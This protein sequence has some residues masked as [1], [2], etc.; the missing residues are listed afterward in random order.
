MTLGRSG[1]MGGTYP[2]T[3]A[4]EVLNFTHE[5]AEEQKKS[6]E[7]MKELLHSYILRIKLAKHLRAFPIIVSNNPC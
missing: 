1:I 4:F 2:W 6:Q 5:T 7:S 3:L